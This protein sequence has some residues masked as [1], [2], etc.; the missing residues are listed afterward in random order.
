[1][2]RICELTGRRPETG[3]KV[4]HSNRKTRTRWLP[5]LKTKK[6]FVLELK[7]SITLYLSARAIKT[8]DKHGGLVP[9]LFNAKESDLSENLKRLK[10][11]VT[12][13][14]AN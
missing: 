4:S 12:K 13:T 3:N 1:M 7:D 6:F 9:A 2:S 5:N 14:R 11:R 10:R 8:I